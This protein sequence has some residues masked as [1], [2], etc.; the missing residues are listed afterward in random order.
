MGFEE[1]RQSP[2]KVRKNGCPFEYYEETGSSQSHHLQFQYLTKFLKYWN[3]RIFTGPLTPRCNGLVEIKRPAGGKPCRKFVL[4][5]R[6]V[7]AEADAAAFLGRDEA[8]LFQDMNV[9]QCIRQHNIERFRKMCDRHGT[10][11]L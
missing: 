3:W 1:E 4:R 2:F 8:G 6:V 10:L 7:D 5:C 9:P 11:R